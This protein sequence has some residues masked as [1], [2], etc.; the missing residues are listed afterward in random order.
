MVQ[1]MIVTELLHLVAIDATADWGIVES[2]SI[3]LGEVVSSVR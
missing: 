3:G 1:Q 2:S